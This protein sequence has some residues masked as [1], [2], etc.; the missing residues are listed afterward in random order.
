MR[1]PNVP[2]AR[3]R[4]SE[5]KK[6]L[7]PAAALADDLEAVLQCW[8]ELRWRLRE[9]GASFFTS[10]NQDRRS[11]DR[12]FLECMS[13]AET[14]HRLEGPSTP[15]IPKDEH[16][17]LREMMLERLGEHPDRERYKRALDYANRP[18]NAKRIAELRSRT[19]RRFSC[20]RAGGHFARPAR[21]HPQLPHPLERQE[22][23]GS[24]RCRQVSRTAAADPGA[25]G[26]PPPGSRPRGCDRQGLRRPELR[27]RGV[28]G[29]ADTDQG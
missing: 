29:R 28:G 19:R 17:R 18:D 4:E 23:E 7:L 21:R 22:E 20:R 3:R 27:E 11:L 24:G 16:R 10:L 12:H 14:Y 26:Q 1:T 13:F 6:V 15:P 5:F 2:L 8:Y 25:T 9:A